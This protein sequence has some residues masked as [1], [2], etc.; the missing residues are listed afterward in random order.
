MKREIK[1]RVGINGLGRIG[2]L[3]L[4]QI[5]NEQNSIFEICAINATKLQAEDY[6]EYIN[7]D[8]VHHFQQKHEVKLLDNQRIQIGDHNIRLFQSREAPN[9]V[10][11]GVEYLIDCT[12]SFLTEDKCKQ[13]NVPFT[14]ISSPAKDKMPTFINGANMES[15]NGENIVS[16]SSCTTNC[17]APM[18]ALLDNHF[19][20]K[21]CVFTTI[22]AATNSQYVTDVIQKGAR[23]DR[24]VFNNII[25]HTTGA[26]SSVTAVLPHLKGKVFGTSVRV[27]VSNCSLVDLNVTLGREDVSLE[28]IEEAI[29][30]NKEFN[31]VFTVTKGKRVSSDYMTTAQPCNLDMGGC[32]DMSK[33]KFK[34]FLWYDNEWSYCA[35]LLRLA[36]HMFSV[37]EPR[38]KLIKQQNFERRFVGNMDLREK[39]V[40]C[41]F[42]F[43]VPVSESGE[44]TDEFRI[45]STVE[46]I[47]LI[48][49]KGAKYIVLASHFGRPEGREMKFSTGFMV[50]I[51]ERHYG[52]KVTFLPDGISEASLEVLKQN[53]AKGIY[54]LENVRFHEEETWYEKEP[55]C[56]N[57]CKMLSNYFNLGDVFVS[58]AFGCTHRKHL[59]VHGMSIFERATEYG[60]QD[61]NKLFGY[62]CLIQKE[63]QALSALTSLKK[64]KRILAVIGGNKIKDKLPIIDALKEIRDCTVFVAGGLARQYQ[65]KVL[66]GNVEVMK[67]G[68]GSFSLGS[69]GEPEYVEDIHNSL[70]PFILDAGTN[71]LREVK[72]IAEESEV[73]FWNG[74]L[75]KIEDDRYR[76]GSDMFV[77]YL[78]S[79]DCANKLIIIGGGETA[80]LF[81]K[82]M[83]KERK[84]IYVSTGGGALL[85]F[86]QKNILERKTLVG[87][88]IFYE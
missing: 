33:G 14:I 15:Y 34:L 82:N 37:N 75:G 1:I 79:N 51:L 70:V 78:L 76:Q 31:Q 26:S 17:L 59:S 63:V 16:G 3:V 39:G 8:S 62:G 32:I 20:V 87:L 35:Q 25:P 36:K 46:T 80:S 27:P 54:L 2:K 23:T 55:Y 77:E 21:E 12:G 47:N 57:C 56:G 68:V 86:L 19:G 71:S 42:D 11:A 6:Q 74:S 44:V 30:D 9:W 13:H 50:P 5:L 88:E 81:D 4:L 73:I 7:Y 69:D 49:N 67:D 22:H 72:K 84:N 53:E 24:T 58:D 10:S 60:F 43:N 85:E 64:G 66:D 52:E 45:S 61:V 65:H 28:T 38:N 83:L 40:V 29:R 48:R 41:R 18:L